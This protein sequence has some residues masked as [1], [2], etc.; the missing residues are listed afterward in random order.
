MKERLYN[1]SFPWKRE[2]RRRSH[3][4]GEPVITLDC[5]VN[6]PVKPEEDNDVMRDFQI[7][8]LSVFSFLMIILLWTTFAFSYDIQTLGNIPLADTLTGISINPSTNTAAAISRETKTLYFIDTQTNTITKKI[9]LEITPSGIA[10]DTNRNQVIVSSSD[11]ILQFIDLNTGNLIKSS[12]LPNFPTSH[13]LNLSSSVVASQH[14]NF[15]TSQLLNSIA[16]NSKTDTL[17]IANDN[18]ITLMDLTTGD[19]IKEG[20]LKAR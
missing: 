14:P 12:Q 2:S 7:K 1:P 6:P 5:P 20:N 4:N 11:G 17:Y 18:S 8:K 16:I 15:P 10:V 3:E 9:S 13:F 19:I